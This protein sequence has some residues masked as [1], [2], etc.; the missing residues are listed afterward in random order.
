MLTLICPISFP[1]KKKK[2]SKPYATNKKDKYNHIKHK[3]KEL[4]LTDLTCHTDTNT[5]KP[6]K[7]DLAGT[8]YS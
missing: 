7:E 3:E 8:K 5:T 2:L 1:K 4:Q 6:Y